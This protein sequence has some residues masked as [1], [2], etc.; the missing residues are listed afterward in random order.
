MQPNSVSG[1]NNENSEYKFLISFG[2]SS[3][4]AHKFQMSDRL[5]AAG[6]FSF[7]IGSFSLSHVFFGCVYSSE[8]AKARSALTHVHKF[9]L[10]GVAGHQVLCA[11]FFDRSILHGLSLLKKAYFLRTNEFHVC[12][13]ITFIE[14]YSL[15]FPVALL[16]LLF[17]YRHYFCRTHTIDFVCSAHEHIFAYT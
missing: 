4:C 10:V 8:W 3:C 7:R 14:W 17:C 9:N 2:L 15:F 1:N 16:L 12:I 6:F 5:L 13:S 11:A